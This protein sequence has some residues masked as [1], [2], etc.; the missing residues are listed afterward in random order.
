MTADQERN[1]A[2]T[3]IVKCLKLG[4]VIHISVPK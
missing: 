3:K 2:F 4:Y 1:A